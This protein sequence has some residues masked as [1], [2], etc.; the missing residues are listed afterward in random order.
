MTYRGYNL[1]IAVVATESLTLNQQIGAEYAVYRRALREREIYQ[2]A[3]A[4][5]EEKLGQ[6]SALKAFWTVDI[7]R[8]GAPTPPKIKVDERYFRIVELLRRKPGIYE[9]S[10]LSIAPAGIH[11]WDREDW[12]FN[13]GFKFQFPFEEPFQ[14][15]YQSTEVVAQLSEE[16]KPTIQIATESAEPTLFLPKGFRIPIEAI[17]SSIPFWSPLYRTERN[18][19]AV[20]EPELT[21]TPIRIHASESL[22]KSIF[23]ETNREAAMIHKSRVVAAA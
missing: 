19:Y 21:A 1:I 17:D 23:F 18:K 14:V 9:L 15:T 5:W 13:Y 4:N 6:M 20:W 16:E 2:T 11:G 8:A 22:P 3:Y 10:G 12:S 7:S